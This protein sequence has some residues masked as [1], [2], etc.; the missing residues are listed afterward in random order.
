MSELM[1]VYFPWCLSNEYWETQV[2]GSRGDTYIV[3]WHKLPQGDTQYGYECTCPAFKF[4]GGKECKH[5]RAVDGQRC[6]WNAEA[7]IGGGT[8]DRP[9]DGKCPKCGG[10][11]SS[12]AVGI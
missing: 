9:A 3:T 11:L 8:T 5:I 12:V 7:V 6:A 4:G 10:E 1:T 2:Q